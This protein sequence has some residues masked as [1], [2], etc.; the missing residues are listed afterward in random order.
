MLWTATNCGVAELLAAKGIDYLV[1]QAWGDGKPVSSKDIQRYR[2]VFNSQLSGDYSGYIRQYLSDLNKVTV[3]PSPTAAA[4]LVT[5][6]NAAQADEK[7]KTGKGDDK[8]KKDKQKKGEKGKPPFAKDAKKGK[9]EGKWGWFDDKGNFIT[10]GDKPGEWHVEP[11][12]H[13]RDPSWEGQPPRKTSHQPY[14]NVNDAGHI[15]H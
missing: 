4:Q 2:R 5:A 11:N 15:T 1:I 14:W 9:K 3:Q 8:D 7:E 13:T 10:T 6:V 12:R